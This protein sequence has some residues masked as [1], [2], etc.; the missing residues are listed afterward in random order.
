MDG[1]ARAI[2]SP[3]KRASLRRQMIKLEPTTLEVTHRLWKTRT[4]KSISQHP[5]NIQ[6]YTFA[7]VDSCLANIRGLSGHSRRAFE[8]Q[9]LQGFS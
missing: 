5:N 1:N 9:A 7:V 3:Y 4:S 2:C 8:L 6:G